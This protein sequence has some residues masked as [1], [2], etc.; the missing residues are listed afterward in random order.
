MV[1]RSAAAHV[2]A[3]GGAPATGVADAI[4][5]AVAARDPDAEGAYLARTACAEC[6]GVQ[7]AGSD[8][9]P[10]LRIAKGYTREQF[11]HFF[12]TG[13]ALGGRD[14]PLMSEVARNRFSHFTDEE[15]DALYAY[16]MARAAAD[17]GA[18]PP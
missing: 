16:L 2:H 6:H 11:A 10:D 12:Q 13:E 18:P 5:D 1:V 15:E 7:L 8:F 14:L 17:Q 4:V 3:G 9:A